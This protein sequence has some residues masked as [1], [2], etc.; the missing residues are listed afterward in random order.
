MVVPLWRTQAWFTRVL[1]LLI[2]TPRWVRV[3]KSV[4]EHPLIHHH[5]LSSQ[6]CLLICKLSGK[7]SLTSAYRQKL[8]TSSYV[9]G[10]RA[11]GSSMTYTSGSGV[12]FVFK[13]IDFLH[14]VVGDVLKFLHNLFKEGLSYSSL[15]TARSALACCFT[16]YQGKED[17]PITRH[18][19]VTKYM[20]GVF[21]CRPP[22]PRYA[23]TWDANIV[24]DYLSLMQPLYKLSL[25]DLSY[26]LVML[27][28]LTSG[29]RC[30]MLA[31]LDTKSMIKSGN[32]FDFSITV[33]AKQDR[34][35]KLF[36]SLRFKKYS[37]RELCVFNTLES[38]LDR[39]QPLRSESKLLISYVRPFKS[40]GVSTIGRWLKTLLGLAGIDT[41][42][43]TAH[44]TRA[45]SASK[46]SRSIPVDE[47]LKHIGWASATTFNRYY[48][49]PIDNSNKNAYDVAVLQ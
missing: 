38:Y 23:V 39:T 20:K 16:D 2:D 43:F 49:K 37:K 45:A 15:N 4:L 29:Q 44:S 13:G 19:L 35:N 21:N 33:L 22:A 3:N 41:A 9:L 24:L 11:Q 46:A 1:D 14:P 18:V 31:G 47:I 8:R 26:K 48:N 36:S 27:M 6:L 30:N 5:P 10:D 28:A 32:G 7:S 12:N 34:P 25:R 42:V 17:R 40:V